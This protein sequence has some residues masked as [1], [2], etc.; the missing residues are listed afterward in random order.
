MPDSY[1][2][3]LQFVMF[4]DVECVKKSS[5]KPYDSMYR[6]CVYVC[7]CLCVFEHLSICKGLQIL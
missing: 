2:L 3:Q 1:S 5:K 7:V 6:V 4:F